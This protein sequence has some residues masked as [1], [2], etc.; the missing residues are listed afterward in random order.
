MGIEGIDDNCLIDQ[1][2][3]NLRQSRAKSLLVFETNRP[4]T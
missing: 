1:V 4:V 2:S 3:T